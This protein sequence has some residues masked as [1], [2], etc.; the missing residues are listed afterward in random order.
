[1]TGTWLVLLGGLGLVIGCGLATWLAAR[2][3]RP[4]GGSHDE[5]ATEPGVPPDTYPAP[6]RPPSSPESFVAPGGSPPSREGR[7]MSPEELGALRRRLAA[8]E[9]ERWA[10]WQRWI[11]EQCT[12]TVEGEYCIPKELVERWERQIAT[13]F[14]QLSEREQ[15]S[16]LEQVDRY[17][18]LIFDLVRFRSEVRRLYGLIDVERQDPDIQVLLGPSE[19]P[20]CGSGGESG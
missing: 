1:M 7:S 4:E 6:R 3:C 9:H 12:V 11:H 5:T 10:D 18:P 13:P 14:E 16:D 8:I 17:W 19:S 2:I 15:A 20:P